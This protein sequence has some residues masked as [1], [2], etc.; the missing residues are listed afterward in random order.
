MN[1][2]CAKQMNTNLDMLTLFY[3]LYYISIKTYVQKTTFEIKKFAFSE[4][5]LSKHLLFLLLFKK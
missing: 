5:E 1:T 4:P 2:K 3:V